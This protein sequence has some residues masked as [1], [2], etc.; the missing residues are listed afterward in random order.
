MS[1]RPL[2]AVAMQHYYPV[3]TS[4]CWS[5]ALLPQP[6]D[7]P[8]NAEVVGF[9]QLGV[10]ERTQY[11]PPCRAGGV[12]EGGIAAGVR[13]LRQHEPQTPQGGRLCS[14]PNALH[15]VIS[16]MCNCLRRTIIKIGHALAR[17]R[18]PQ[19]EAQAV[20]DAPS[21]IFSY[22]LWCRSSRG[23]CLRR[24]V[25]RACAPLSPRVRACCWSSVQS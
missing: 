8:A 12:P 23:W 14:A 5:P 17:D 16:L 7:W 20:L 2:A 11:Q 21:S 3:P 13:R 4:Y 6:A 10:S 25:R 15:W 19:C 9:C 22:G 18:G 24:C 1:D